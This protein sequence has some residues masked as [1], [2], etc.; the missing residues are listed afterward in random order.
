MLTIRLDDK[1]THVVKLYSGFHC[2]NKT[3]CFLTGFAV[4][5]IVLFGHLKIT[6]INGR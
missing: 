1:N 5:C 2:R 6:I 3:C 4:A